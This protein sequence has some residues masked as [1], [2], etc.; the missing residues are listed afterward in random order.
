MF[1]A[2]AI[3]VFFFYKSGVPVTISL[4]L[5][6]FHARPPYSASMHARRAAA[7]LCAVKHPTPVYQGG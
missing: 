4:S 2:P 6:R 5:F 3:C 1:Q 7:V